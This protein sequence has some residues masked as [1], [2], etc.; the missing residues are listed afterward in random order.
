[1]FSSI[2][3]LKFVLLEVGGAGHAV[4]GDDEVG[5]GVPLVHPIFGP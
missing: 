3:P 1:M 2:V 4:D 5:G